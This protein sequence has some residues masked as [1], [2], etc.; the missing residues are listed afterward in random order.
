[1]KIFTHSGHLGDILYSLPAVKILTGSEGAVI[2]IKDVFEDHRGSVNGNCGPEKIGYTQY[3]AIKDLLLLQPYI[4]EVRS[5]PCEGDYL[6]GHWSGLGRKGKDFIDLDDS[7]LQD[8]YVRRY[9]FNAERYF[10]EFG[11][12]DDWRNHIPWLTIDDHDETDESFAIFHV[13]DRWHGFVPNWSKYMDEAR[14]KY[15][16]IIFTGYAHDHKKFV[17][18]FGFIWHQPTDTLLDLAR[19]IRDCSAL[20]CNQNCSLVIAQG[21]GKK[22]Y[23][24]KNIDRTHCH[25][26]KEFQNENIIS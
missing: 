16:K 12:K 24:S 1:M 2:Y 15:D 3:D 22:Y 21:L 7:R 19:L 6:P 20:Y 8:R 23:L 10:L 18:E 13:T 26:G 5:Y 14:E 11:I 17:E 9:H 4:K 25:M